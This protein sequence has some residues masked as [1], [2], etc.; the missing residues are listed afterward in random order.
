[1]AS[2]KDAS[3]PEIAV[4]WDQDKSERVVHISGR[5]TSDTAAHLESAIVGVGDR[6]LVLDLNAVAEIDETCAAVLADLIRRL[7][8]DRVM[9]RL[10]ASLISAGPS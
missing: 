6:H 1:M 8:D 2:L 3:Q 7:G 10:P 4:S 9:I 5:L